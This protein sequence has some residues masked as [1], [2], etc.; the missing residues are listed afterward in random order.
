MITHFNEK[1]LMFSL[2][3]DTFLLHSRKLI[4]FRAQRIDFTESISLNQ[5]DWFS[6][7]ETS[8]YKKTMTTVKFSI[9]SF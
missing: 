3:I 4:R 2:N 1:S 7:L 5:S 6:V 9:E 8:M